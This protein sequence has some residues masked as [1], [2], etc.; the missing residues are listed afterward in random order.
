MKELHPIQLREIFV[1]QLSVVVNDQKIAMEETDEV[2]V[3]LFVGKPEVDEEKPF[4]AVGMRAIAIPKE[5]PE[6]ASP[7]FKIEVELAGQFEVDYSRF[8]AADIDRWAEVNAPL[9]IIPFLREHLWG[10]GMRAGIRRIFLPLVISKPAK[11]Q[12]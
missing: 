3:S 2:K 6:G 11:K 4:V 10:I 1:R 5:V 8:D 7:A 9:L 12:T